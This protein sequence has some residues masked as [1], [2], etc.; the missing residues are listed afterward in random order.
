MTVA[1]VLGT[2]T[3]QSFEI[4]VEIAGGGAQGLKV[5]KLLGGDRVV[6]ATGRDE[7]P[8]TWSGAFR[9]ANSQAR[10]DALDQIRAQG[11]QQTLTWADR[12]YT[13]VVSDF[14]WRWQRTY[15]IL[16]SIT[17]VVVAD[18]SAQTDDT[19]SSTLDDLVEGDLTLALAL[20]V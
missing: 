20:L 15:Q 7:A 6:D 8:L 5:H 19:T 9:G 14:T 10:C 2:V 16:Y 12:T 17:C 13:V 18:N 11:Q 4:P 1:L 3:F